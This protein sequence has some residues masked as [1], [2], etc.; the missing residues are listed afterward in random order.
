MIPT[1]PRTFI[2]GGKMTRKRNIT[3]AMA[4]TAS[5][6]LLAGLS[7]ASAQMGGAPG[8]PCSSTVES[9]AYQNCTLPSSSAP[10]AGSFPGSFLVPGTS[11]SFAVHG[12]IYFEVDHDLGQHQGG[13]TNAGL[14]F[15]NLEGLGVAGS[16]ATGTN[17]GTYMGDKGTR[18]NIETRTPTAYGEL[19]TYIEMDFNQLAGA[20][21]NGNADLLR[22]RMAYGTLG[23][24]LM[25]QTLTLYEDPQSYADTADASQDVGELQSGI[26]RKPQIRYTYLAGNGLTVAASAEISTYSTALGPTVGYASQGSAVHTLTADETSAVVGAANLYASVSPSAA[27]FYG[28]YTNW[29]KIVLATQWDQ[30]WGHLKFAAAGGLDEVRAASTTNSLGL[31]AGNTPAGGINTQNPEYAFSLTGHVNT[32]G[33]D[34]LRGGIR[35]NVSA[36]DY[37][38]DMYEG[39]TIYNSSSAGNPGSGTRAAV[40]MWA[41]FGSYEHFFNNQWRA[42]ASFGFAQLHGGDPQF[43]AITTM[44]SIEKEHV[45]AHL[46]AIYSPVPQLD[47]ITEWMYDYR[48]TRSGALGTVNRIEEQFKFY[49]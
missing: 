44:A 6:A 24:W 27:A 35:Y 49:F 37:S 28:G 38:D 29:P 7:P 10:G 31:G 39:G 34:A 43:G 12:I 2:C 46:N 45:S 42:N 17:G 1:H 18:P 30:P 14:G 4:T 5:V 22:L 36:S 40:K 8:G 32:W 41:I 3:A 48:E 47:A 13:D 9:P 25:G 15:I 23:P 20:Q 19:K 26:V 16:Q 33:K 11:T 21:I